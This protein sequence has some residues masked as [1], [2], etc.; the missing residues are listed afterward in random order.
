MNKPKD[1]LYTKLIK[2][3]T[4]HDICQYMELRGIPY[5]LISND[6]NL[7]V[8]SK[9]I[10]FRFESNLPDSRLNAVIHINGYVNA[11][12][13]VPEIEPQTNNTIFIG[14]Y[15]QNTKTGFIYA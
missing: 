5:T 13:I 10:C 14:C 11:D 12:A 6:I 15:L 3:K 7:E 2:L 4:L 9:P 1:L 8:A